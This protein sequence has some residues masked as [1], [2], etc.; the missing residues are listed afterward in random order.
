LLRPDLGK[1]SSVENFRG[2]KLSLQLRHILG[3]HVSINAQTKRCLKIARR[4]GLDYDLAC[5]RSSSRGF[6]YALPW[7]ARAGEQVTDWG[8]PEYWEKGYA[9][10]FLSRYRRDFLMAIDTYAEI[11][12]LGC[13]A[14]AV[15]EQ[16]FGLS[17]L[18]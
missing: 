13:P 18:C 8:T 16:I 11:R 1:W 7:P 2:E 4:L 5:H 15:S 10:Q 6:V 3:Y 12:R 9:L 17:R 14:R